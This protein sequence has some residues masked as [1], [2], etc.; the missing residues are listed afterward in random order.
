MAAVAVMVVRKR[1]PA[2]T[3]KGRERAR[4]L[5]PTQVEGACAV[6]HARMR[7]A[8]ESCANGSAHADGSPT[9]AR[10]NVDIPF[11][12]VHSIEHVFSFPQAAQSGYALC[13][14]T[15]GAPGG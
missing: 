14:V 3:P 1:L 4:H 12:A 10:R 11:A 6:P 5:R 2:Q 9:A 8:P 15:L 13:R 7:V